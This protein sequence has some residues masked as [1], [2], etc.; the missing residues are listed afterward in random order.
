MSILHPEI[1]IKCS[2]LF[3]K[4][5]YPEAV[6]KSFKIVRDRLRILTSFE[7]GSE[8]FGRGRLRIKGAAAQNVDFDFI[9]LIVLFMFFPVI[10]LASQANSSK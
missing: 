7:T 4:E 1:Y 3:E 6:E 5:E 2:S 8:A 9:S 10:P